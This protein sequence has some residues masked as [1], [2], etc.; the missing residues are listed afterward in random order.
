MKILGFDICVDIVVGN[1]MF[2]G[3]FGGQRKCVII[4]KVIVNM[5][6]FRN[7]K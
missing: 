7:V 1:E 3:I 6:N 2:C 4:G 5:D